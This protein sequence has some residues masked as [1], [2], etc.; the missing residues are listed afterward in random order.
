MK[1]KSTLHLSGA[2]NRLLQFAELHSNSYYMPVVIC[3]TLSKIQ[4]YPYCLH[5]QKFS[6]KKQTFDKKT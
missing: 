2:T 4:K 5:L 1:K 3:K 6:L